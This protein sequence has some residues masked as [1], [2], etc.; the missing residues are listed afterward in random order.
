MSPPKKRVCLGLD[1]IHADGVKSPLP[2]DFTEA[3]EPDPRRA[4]FDDVIKKDKGTA[5]QGLLSNPPR[6]KIYFCLE[7][8]T[9]SPELPYS[10]SLS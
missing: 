1:D 6:V 2:L 3:Q 7:N 10:G 8:K 4:Q 5:L 9:E